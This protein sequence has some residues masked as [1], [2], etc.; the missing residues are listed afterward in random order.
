MNPHL[1]RGLLLYQQRRHALAVDEVALSLAVDPDDAYAHALMALCL[2]ALDRHDKAEKEAGAAIGLGPDSAFSH[3]ALALV[4]S[5]RDDDSG[6]LVAVMEAV[7]LE[8][9]DADYQA[10]RAGVL[11]DLRRWEEA[12][13][14]AGQA[15]ESDPE[16]VDANNVRAMALVKLGQREAAGA[17]LDAS[18]ARDPDNSWTHANRGWTLLDGGSPKVA[19]GHFHESL[20]LDPGN[21]WARQ[22]VVE[23]MKAHNPVYALMLRY[24]LW[25]AKLSRGGQWAVIL[26]AVVGFRLLGALAG[27]VP[28]ATLIVGPIALIYIFFVWL[29]WTAT[30][31]SNLCLRLNR[32]GRL[33]LTPEQTSESNWVGLLVALMAAALGL[34]C[35]EGH[36]LT[37]IVVAGIC[38]FLTIPVKAR[39]NVHRGWPRTVMSVYAWVM[40]AIG[41][42]AI[43]MLVVSDHAPDPRA[44]KMGEVALGLLISYLVG[45]FLCGWI[46]NGLAGVRLKK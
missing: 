43:G 5:R 30:P 13:A 41:V 16:H 4:R 39:Y 40:A 1:Q 20:R 38:A 46:A 10:L 45:L 11:Y 44:E 8:P 29:T 25:M 34:A 35:F 31:L 7:R 3:Y 26:G 12:L 18:L 42:G 6:A 21:A 28:G 27:A 23:A 33:A 24:T 36:A 37:W 17:T 2:S 14:A 9:V 19:L 15:L 22:G 32:H